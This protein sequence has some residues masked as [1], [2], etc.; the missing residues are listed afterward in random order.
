M[1]L[2]ENRTSLL[3]RQ[4]WW[5]NLASGAPQGPGSDLGAGGTYLPGAFTSSV[6]SPT[7]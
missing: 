3:W 6:L 4:K 2:K 1:G 7:N 5:L